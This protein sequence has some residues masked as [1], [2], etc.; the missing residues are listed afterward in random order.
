MLL[1]TWA[2]LCVEK[3][4]GPWRNNKEIKMVLKTNAKISMRQLLDSGVH[5]GHQ[6]RRWNPKMAPYIH[7]EQGG[8]YI[9][10]LQQ[11]LEAIDTSYRFIRDT[12]AKGGT[13][14]FVGTKKQAQ[15]AVESSA[16]RCKMPYVNYRWLGGMLTNFNTIH[17]RVK[18]MH[19]YEKKIATGESSQMIKKE[20]L[21][22]TRELEKLRKN[23]TG[24]QSMSKTP[25]A[26]FVIDTKKEAIAVEEANK[27]GIP[28][29]A[30]VDTNCDPDVIDYVIPGNDDAI[31][32]S[33]LL[34]GVMAEAVIEGRQIFEATV[35]NDTSTSQFENL[36]AEEIKEQIEREA[37]AQVQAKEAQAKIEE[38]VKKSKEKTIAEAK[39]A[40]A[41]KEEAAQDAKDE[42]IEAK[43]EE[44]EKVAAAKK[45]SSKKAES[46][47]K[48]SEAKEAKAAKEEA[49]E[50]AK[51]DDVAKE[52]VQES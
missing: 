52:E 22:L 10:D 41:A 40:K 7:S 28:V 31:R 25:S 18:K 51:Q 42:K 48:E 15:D 38:K 2:T 29:V 33:R 9:I 21:K 5:F 17:S 26:I 47:E 43:K 27:L 6:T 8:N 34:A 3:S 19:E 49:K 12:V 1:R 45:T 14:L 36:T 44:K 30:V 24:V 46:K 50:E 20:A 37:K 11:T 23:L 35:E 13:V 16:N 4:T 39:E 32:A